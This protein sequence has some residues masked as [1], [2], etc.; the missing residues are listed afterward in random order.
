LVDEVADVTLAAILPPFVVDVPDVEE[1]PADAAGSVDLVLDRVHRELDLAEERRADAGPH[2]RR[3]ELDVRAGHALIRRA[4]V[5]PAHA[6]EAV[7]G[8]RTA[9]PGSLLYA[10]PDGVRAH[11]S[12][13]PC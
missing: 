13:G 3:R 2:D 4:A 8:D 6:L 1:A 5:L 10:G 7:R 11:D 12:P 9:A